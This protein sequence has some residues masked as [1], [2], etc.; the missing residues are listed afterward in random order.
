MAEEHELRGHESPGPSIG[1]TAMLNAS[2]GKQGALPA[3]YTI[4]RSMTLDEGARFRRRPTLS[5]SSSDPF[6]PPRRR[7][8]TFSEQ[9]LGEARDLFNPR[10]AGS[11]PAEDE[12]SNWASVPLAF[13][14]LPALG[15][16]LFKNGSAVVTD[17][18]L[19]G[20]AAIFLHW[21]VTQP[22]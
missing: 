7:S 21:S 11:Q 6:G 5:P 10:P 4:R 3:S 22:W 17:V 8:T 9:S 1:G 15:G 19:L 20:L 2:A 18:M 16:V 13:A 12:G 14:L